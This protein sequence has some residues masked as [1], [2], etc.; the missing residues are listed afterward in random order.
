MGLALGYAPLA[1]GQTAPSP[2]KGLRLQAHPIGIRL[3]HQG[4]SLLGLGLWTQTEQLRGISLAGVMNDHKGNGA[5]LMLSGLMNRSSR[6]STFTGVSIAPL[7]NGSRGDFRGLQIG[8][9]NGAFHGRG[10]VQIGAISGTGDL[11]GVQLSSFV[12]LSTGKASGL[13]LGA[14]N[15]AGSARGLVQLGGINAVASELRGVQI[16]AYNYAGTLGSAQIG[17]INTIGATAG[18]VQIGLVN[19]SREAKTRQIG[20]MNVLPDTR[21]QFLVGGGSLT[22][23]NLAVRFRRGRGYSQVGLGLGYRAFTGKFSGSL[24]YHRGLIFPLSSRLSLL[25]DL[26]VA[27]I[28]D[29]PLQ[30]DGEANRRYA[31]ASRLSLE[32]RIT[33]LLGAYILGGYAYSRRYSSPALERYR[34]IFEAGITIN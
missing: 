34:P 16:G 6:E 17:L 18:G 23:G 33:Q 19:V 5:G 21:I 4:H 31:F 24:S 28:E 12:N 11:A 30:K 32:Y 10:L 3:Q 9:I 7:L 26:G 29:T 25:G 20:L 22:K 15:V 1:F 2:S 13:Q 14:V 8:A 27:H